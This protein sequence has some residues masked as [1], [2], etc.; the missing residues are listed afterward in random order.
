[1]PVRPPAP[2]ARRILA[3][4]GGFGWPGNASI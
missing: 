2:H 1:M 4:R 3:T